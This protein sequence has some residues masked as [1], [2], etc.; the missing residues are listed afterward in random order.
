MQVDEPMQRT[1]TASRL[2]ERV[3]FPTLTGEVR[4]RIIELRCV[5]P[6]LVATTCR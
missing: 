1:P 5:P 3:T 2:P 4:I 6:P